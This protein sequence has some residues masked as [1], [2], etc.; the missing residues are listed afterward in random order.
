VANNTSLKTK[1]WW[2]FVSEIWHTFILPMEPLLLLQIL[3]KID[4]KTKLGFAHFPSFGLSIL[5]LQKVFIQFLGRN[6]QK[7]SHWA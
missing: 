4:P 2:G 7:L 6:F 5:L 1:F 3:K